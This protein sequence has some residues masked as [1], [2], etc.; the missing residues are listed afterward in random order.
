MKVAKTLTIGVVLLV[1]LAL[2][3]ALLVWMTNPRRTLDKFIEAIN[4]KDH[5]TALAYVSPDI[6]QSRKDNID[7]FLEDWVISDTLSTIVVTDESWRSRTKMTE[8]EQGETVPEINKYGNEA[9]EKKPT[10]K[11]WAHHYQAYVTVEFDDYE[12]PVIIKLKRKTDNTWSRFAQLFRGWQ[13]TQIKY[14]PLDESDY[15]DFEFDFGDEDFDFEDGDFE[16]EVDEE[17]NLV[18]IEA[19]DEEEDGD[20]EE[21]EEDGLVE[22]EEDAVDTEDEEVS[23][24]ETE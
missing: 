14:Q 24:D 21:V 2:V 12:D 22:D 17:G 7:W 15:E 19:E 13:V 8:N 23:S 11:Y 9:L 18:P 20:E 5:A 4:N 3:A 6:K 16:F 1:I 10:P